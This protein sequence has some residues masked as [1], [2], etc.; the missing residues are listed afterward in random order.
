MSHELRT[1]LSAVIGYSEMLEEEM[2]DSARPRLL[3]DLGKI[4]TNARHLLGLINDVLDLSKIE[5]DRMESYAE[6]FDVATL[7]RGSGRHR[8][9]AGQRKNN[10]PGARPSATALGAMHTDVV[11]LRQCLFN[12]LSNA[13]KFT[14]NGHITLQA[15][16]RRGTGRGWSSPCRDTGIGMTE[17][18]LGRLFQ[19]FTPGRRDAPRASSAAPGSAWRSPG[20]SAGCWAATWR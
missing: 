1:P 7:R 11:K 3:A 14:E 5:A 9:R 8:G 17:E 13:A 12:L 18:Q 20:R 16:A 4:K 2:E 6:D 19:R 10:T 15:C